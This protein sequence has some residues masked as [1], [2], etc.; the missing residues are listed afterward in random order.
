MSLLALTQRQV[1][2]MKVVQLVV[3]RQVLSVCRSQFLKVPKK[4]VQGAALALQHQMQARMGKN[5]F[6]LASTPVLGFSFKYILI[7]FMDDKLGKLWQ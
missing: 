5:M 3:E 2:L 6:L 7:L 4:L 1:R